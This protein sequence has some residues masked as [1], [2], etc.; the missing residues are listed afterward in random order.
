MAVYHNIVDAG[1]LGLLR[2]GASDVWDFTR[3]QYLRAGSFG[4]SGVSITRASS[5]YAETA[6]GTLVNFGSGVLRRTDRGVLIEGARTNLVLR[7]QEF[8]NAYWE[9]RVDSS[10]TTVTANTHVAPDGTT[11]AD[12]LN[13]VST[14]NFAEI[15]NSGASLISVTGSTQYVGSIYVRKTTGATTFPQVYLFSSGGASKT[16]AVFLDT[17]TGT[18]TARTGAAPDAFSVSALADYWRV[19]WSITTAAADNLLGMYITPTF[20]SLPVSAGASLDNSVTGT[21]V[22][23][24]AQLEEAAFASSYIPTVAS[25]V[26]R[27]ADEVLVNPYTFPAPFSAYAE[28]VP[29]GNAA[30]QNAALTFAVTTA[31]QQ[32]YIGN[33][34]GGVTQRSASLYVRNSADQAY[35]DAGAGTANVGA[36]V[37]QAVRVG[38]NDFASS[39]GGSAVLTDTSGTVP[40]M[41]RIRFGNDVDN[42]QFMFG[43]LRRAAIF[44]SALSD[45]QLQAITT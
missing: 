26:T 43:Y 4:A 34:I 7:S 15:R 44:P 38:A 32:I 18:A 39:V 33:N 21:V 23:W 8:D 37:R 14:T 29:G 3:D 10:V 41:D 19:Q 22:C 27:A 2:A 16:A 42:T 30:S 28:Y 36:T 20:A 35:L 9:K 5:G 45:A 40:T 6:A 31:S 11:T 25:T 24:G 1:W 17:N 12:S 13:D